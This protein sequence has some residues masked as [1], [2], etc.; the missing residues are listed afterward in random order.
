MESFE[1]GY[2]HDYISPKT[3]AYL[4]KHASEVPGVPGM[5]QIGANAGLETQ[6]ALRFLNDLYLKIKADLKNVLTQ[7]VLDRQFIDERVKA[8]YELNKKLDHDFL[9]KDYQTILGLEDSKGRIVIGPKNSDYC[10][11]ASTKPIAPIP[12]FMK[13]PH[14]TLFGPPGTEKMAI[15]AMNTYHRKLKDEPPIVAKLLQTHEGN[16]KWGADDEDSKTPLR[17]DLVSSAVNLT[18][19]FEGELNYND[20]E[21]GK[22]YSLEKDHL[23]A[24]IKR[25]PGLA[26]PST[27]LFSEGSPIPLHLYDFA[28]HL[29]HNWNRPEALVF[30][31]PKLENEEEAAYIHKMISV[32]EADIKSMH[33]SY[34]LGT[35]RLMIVLENPRAILRTHEIMDAL[36]PYFVGASLGWHDYLGSTAR[37]FKE[38]ANYRIPVKADPDIVIKYIKASH[39]LLADVVGSRGGIKVGGMYGILPLDN[40]RMSESF[41][42]TIKG[43]IKDVVTQ[44]KRDLTGFWVAHPDFVR[45]GMALVEAW[46]F[47]AQGNS[48]PLFELVNELLE[49]KHRNEVIE[50]IKKPDM[51][52]LDKSDSQYVRSLIVADIKE[53]DFIANNHP[54]EIRYNVFQ[55]LQYI[56]DWL[57]GNGCVALPAH[58][59]G[60]AVRVMDD[61]ATAERSRWEVWHEIYHGRF[62]VEEFLKIAFEEYHFIRKDLSDDKKI[63]QVKWNSVTEKWYPVALHLMIQLMT[64]KKPVEFATELL[65]PFTVETVREATDPLTVLNQIDPDKYALDPF[66][67]RF[68]H[69]FEA[70]GCAKFA[71]AMATDVVM[72]LK[73]AEDLVYGFNLDEVKEAAHFHGNIGEGKKTLDGFAVKEQALVFDESEN[74]KIELKD[75]GRR[76]LDKFGVKFLISAQGKTGAEM[77]KVL[78]H[79]LLNSEETELMNAKEALWAITLKRLQEK[80]LNDLGTVIDGLKKKYKVN[81]ADIAINQNGLNQNLKLGHDGLWYELASLSKPLAAAFSI[82]YF[83]AKNISLDTPVNLLLKEYGSGYRIENPEWGDKVLLRHLMSHCALNMHYVN[84]AKLGELPAVSKLI[85][86]H[87]GLKYAKVDA[88]CEPGTEFHYSGGGFLVLE[89]LIETIEKRPAKEVAQGFFEKL[90]TRELS[91]EQNNLPGIKYANGI[92]DDGKEVSGGRL[93]FPSFAAGA[94]GTAHGLSVFLNSLTDSYHSLRG[95]NAISHDTAIEMLHGFDKGCRD[96]MGCD[97]GLGIFVAECGD[98]KLALHQGA[99]EGFRCLFVHCFA[100]PNKGDG[101]VVLCNAD[102]SGVLFIAEVAQEILRALNIKGI[103]FSKFHSEYDFKNIKQEQIVNLGYKKLIFEAFNPTLPEEI[104]NKGPADP[105]AD[106]NLLTDAKI[107]SVT[108]QKFARAENMISRYL[109]VFEPELFGKQG[110]IMDSWETARHNPL[111]F[112][113]VVLELSQFS[114]IHYVHLSTKFHDGNQAQYVRIFASKGD[115]TQWH[116]ILPKTLMVGHGYINI[117]LPEVVSQVKRIKVDMFPDG[118]LSRVGLYE[119]LPDEAEAEFLPLGSAACKRFNDEIPK[120][121]KPLSLSYNVN[122][123]IVKR[124]IEVCLAEANPLNLAGL[125]Y[126]AKIV[127]ATNEHYGPAAQVISPFPPI[128]MFDGMESSRSRKAGHSESVTVQLARASVLKRIVL[129]FTYF[130]NNNPREVAVEARAADG[131]WKQV[132][133]PTNVKA[134]AGNKK[135]FT[136]TSSEVFSQV[137]VITIPDGGINRIEIY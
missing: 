14:V 92:F 45:L 108:N 96:F 31:V 55:S 32:A 36:Y 117:E 52:G 12:E 18:R 9:S 104:I 26:L 62:S 24:P 136:V 77:L 76:Y 137:K 86:G 127:A 123:S 109:P 100:G 95:S 49:E 120:A 1:I 80:P 85:S 98:N 119:S 69:Y 57:S 7:R 3:A 30:Y 91:F 111:E 90:Q 105:L 133:K 128:H 107:I 5:A 58:V 25:F 15:N 21:N 124:N 59:H 74:I 82:E 112:D 67:K 122:E 115:K 22:T 8:C 48:L 10:N 44:M 50:F 78:Q 60:T 64:A 130:V 47:H 39:T 116:E 93:A 101:L 46:K 73:K 72:D 99:N 34:K 132:V 11:A 54:S 56:T 2:Y 81:S 135:E 17:S 42:I 106:Y 65:I 110:K 79:R 66:V 29:F 51:A 89:H 125:A 27:F 113:S 87:E 61:L 114:D 43:Y 83:R 103:D 63:V 28:L 20:P 121:K 84:G 6:D 23:A 37:L 68:M 41:Q 97:M 33:P 134:F 16:P 38:D 94:M 13:G 126:G 40:N 70:C 118:G 75:W 129:D 35:V 71:A 88:I 53:S 19:C 102:N 131:T 4:M